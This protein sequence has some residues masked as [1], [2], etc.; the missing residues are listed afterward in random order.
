MKVILLKDVPDIGKQRQII[1]VKA[2][3]ANNF[4]LAKG[5]A[6]VAN[7]ANMKKLNDEIAA[8]KALEAQIKQE[9]VD[10][11]NSI[12]DKSVTLKAKSG[13]DG[14]LYGAVTSKDIAD[15]ILKDLNVDID[16]RKIL[17]DNIKITGTYTVKIKLHPEVEAQMEV[18]IESI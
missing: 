11:K 10:V 18:K 1:D 4:L 14:K 13:P 12:N 2:G 16:K 3:F 6:V 9:A 15:A 7:D 5:L 17:S 8:Q